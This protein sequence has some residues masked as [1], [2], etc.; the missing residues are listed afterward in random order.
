MGKIPYWILVKNTKETISWSNEITAGYIHIR[1]DKWGDWRLSINWKTVG[2]GP[3]KKMEA[4]ARE[5]M[6]KYIAVTNYPRQISYLRKIGF[7]V[8]YNKRME[9]YV[10]KQQ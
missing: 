1:K 3:R 9:K 7:K 10:V 8:K 2:Y 4:R 6:K 5:Y